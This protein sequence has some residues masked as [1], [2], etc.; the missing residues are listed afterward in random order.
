MAALHT[1]AVLD[2]VDIIIEE[3]SPQA[4]KMGTQ[5]QVYTVPLKNKHHALLVWSSA[6]CTMHAAC[7]PY[8]YVHFL[9]NGQLCL[10]SH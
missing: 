1:A 10:T 9:S 3:I 4:V 6:C 2:A 8:G 5:Y 7:H